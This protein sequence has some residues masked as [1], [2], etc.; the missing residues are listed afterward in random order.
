LSLAG[1]VSASTVQTKRQLLRGPPNPKTNNPALWV[2][3]V[4]GC[5]GGWFVILAAMSS[6]SGQPLRVTARRCA[7]FRDVL[8]LPEKPVV[9]A[10]DMPIGLLDRPLPGGRACDREARKLLGRPRASSVF[11]PPTRPGL[12]ALAYS[13]VSR[14]NGAGMSKE[15][16]NILPKIRDVDEAIA[17]SDQERVFEAHPELA[18]TALAGAPIR[19]NKKTAEGRR[20]RVRLLRRIFGRAFQDP[21][22]LRL[23]H[24]AAQVALDDVVDAY[25]LAHVAARIRR[26]SAARLPVAPLRDRRGLRME[27]WY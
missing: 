18:F 12:A 20:A 13:D 6:N 25:V 11:T 4:D 1:A 14:V 24:G 26:G 23:E 2:A 3:G 15:A 22:R 21:V 16:F 19:H 7:S 27:I 8:A 17:A 5:R 10:V 9:L